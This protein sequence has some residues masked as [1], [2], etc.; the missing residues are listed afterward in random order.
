MPEAPRLAKLIGPSFIILG[1]GLGSGELIL[2]PYLASN[3]GLGIVW[4]AV[5]GIT[6]QFFLNMEIERY[7]LV[8]GESVF[9][10]WRKKWGPAA[11]G[12]FI[13]ST[14]I[15]WM[16]PGIMAA[17]ATAAA[18]A[19]GVAYS[20]WWG[21][22]MLVALGGIYSLGRVVYRTQE[23]VQK[24]I[25]LVGVPLVV[26]LTIWLA[27][28]ADWLALAAGVAR[29][30]FLPEGIPLA[31]FLAALVYSGAG[32]NLNLAQSLYVKEKG[33]GMGKYSGHIINILAGRE[34]EVQLTGEVFAQT[35]GNISRF[36]TWWRRINLEHGLVFWATGVVTMLLLMLLAYATVHGHPEIGSSIKFVLL[37]AKAMGGLGVAFLVAVA[38]MLFGTQFA[39]YG[40][41]ARMATEN[42]AL[43]IPGSKVHHISR[44]FYG[45]LWLQIL[46][47]IVV[48]GAG[49]IEP[50]ALVVTGAVLNA[51][52]MCVYSWLILG[53]NL[54]LPK[55]LQPSWWRVAI[56]GL[57]GLIYGGFTIFTIWNYLI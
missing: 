36:K 39:V 56:V 14:I 35:E 17:A 38:L 21:I 33:Y 25:I 47:G 19:A 16:W 57:A 48:F 12:W 7:S 49:F 53:L 50:L 26:G 45:F 34:E 42:L 24:A 22:G 23:T 5:V 46:A 28:R 27:G 9:A 6:L 40:S 30:G 2:W 8:T 29:V 54:S 43:L 41:N 52:A 3:F 31:T 37:E 4:A 32:G 13:A 55:A 11:A 20:K 1:V 10:G 51:V 44:F 15:P 18:T